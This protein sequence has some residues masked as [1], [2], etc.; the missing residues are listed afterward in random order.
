VVPWFVLRF[1]LGRSLKPTFPLLLLTILASLP[2]PLYSRDTP[3]FSFPLILLASK[4][5]TRHHSEVADRL[6]ITLVEALPN[7]LPMF[8][9]K[10]IEY[11]ESTFNDNKINLMT[12][13]MVKDVQEKHIVVQDA[14]KE[15]KEIP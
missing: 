12:K 5:L 6:K 13:T 14:N 1:F 7:V 4:P 15:I 9:K 11:T 10:L 3:S 2:F 8:S